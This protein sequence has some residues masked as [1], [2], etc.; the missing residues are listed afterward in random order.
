MPDTETDLITRLRALTTSEISDAL[1]KHGI[2]GQALGISAV[3]GTERVV[4]PAF[5]LFYL[6]KGESDGTVGD[7]IDDVPEGHVV[8]I[9]N[10]GRLD[11][12]VWGNILCEVG[13]LRGVG[14]VVIDGICRDADLAAEIGFPVFARA[15]AMRT[16]KDR[17]ALE[18]ANCPVAVAGVRV[19]PADIVV[20]DAGGV[21]FVPRVRLTEVIA[22]AEAIAE[23]ED[24]ILDQTRAGEP[25]SRARLELGYHALQTPGEQA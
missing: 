17:V 4:G 21:V 12:T 5:T 13:K 24:R 19:E 8:V 1:D 9:D 14:G 23:R 20:A 11:C 18:A 16:G 15:T 3:F 6:P 25:L 7:F 22:T 10:R 2:A